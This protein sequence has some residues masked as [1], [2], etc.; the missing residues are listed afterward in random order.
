MRLFLRD[1]RHGVRWLAQSPGVAAAALAALALS[2]G[3]NT[4]IFSVV[5]TVL[6]KPLPVRDPA[7]L[8]QFRHYNEQRKMSS[9]GCNYADVADWRRELASFESIAALQQA[10][11]NLTGR[12]LSERVQVSKV[13]ANFLPLLGVRP[14]LGRDFLAGDD[15]PGAGRVAL[16]GHELWKRSFGANPDVAGATAILDGD[17]YTVIGV[18]PQGFRFVGPREEKSDLYVPLA[19]AEARG[20]K[21]VTVWAFGRLKPGVS[22]AQVR[23]ELDRAG[24]P[25]DR[26]SR[27]EAGPIGEWIVPDVRTG[28]YVLL[29]AVTLVLLIGC[30]NVASLLV[31][32]AAGRRR[33]MAIRAALGAG[34][35]RLVMQLLAESLPLGLAGGALGVLLAW[36]GIGLLPLVD[37]SRIPRLAD[38]RLDGAMLA[39]TAAVSI[40]TC[41][42]FSLA[43]ALDL[44]RTRLHETLKEGGRGGAASGRGGR[45]R[46]ALIVAEIAI[47]LVLAVGAVLMIRT[48]RNLTAVRPGFNPDHLLT[49]SVDLPRTRYKSVEQVQ[50]FHREA[51]ERIRAA[52][53]V[54]A[55]SVTNS[56]P[57]GGNYFRADFRV[58]GREYANPRE[59]P[60][61][62]L[63]SVDRDYL[64]TMQIRLV[65]GRFFDDRDRLGAPLAALIN[66]AAARRL[67][68]N[69]DPVGQRIGSPGQW[70]TVIGLVADIRH[71]DVSQESTSE[72]LIAFEQLPAMTLALT[73]R[74]DPAVYADP[75]RFAPQLRRAVES[76]DRIVALHRTLSMERIMANR[77]APR[78][79][80]MIV[81]ALFTVLALTL[82]AVGVY[83]VLAYSV[84]RR[85]QEIGI[86]MALGAGRSDVVGLVARESITLAAVGTAVGLAAA[87]GLTRLASGLL[88][89]VTPLD[90]IAYLGAAACLIAV[91][92]LASYIPARRA[93]RLDPIAAL[94]YE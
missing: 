2:I 27:I 83:G 86:R 13:N 43:P 66:Q 73:V 40:L 82:A 36:W 65:R 81:L 50:N 91:A 94:R 17:A 44:S 51:V 14:V 16:L 22:P 84:E 55:V 88:F 67:F 1:C 3:A 85:T 19:V 38:T 39:L 28:L 72:V 69:S 10:P 62:D 63:R 68:E 93:A 9:S 12:E 79:L 57:L 20:P 61:L 37:S 33:E 41:V 45:L 11:M 35:G 92:A 58:E 42:L 70:F 32:R 87:A 54:A 77:L 59:Y 31:A 48:F 7:G 25:P 76:V 90:P 15:R 71:T 30:A 75:L 5:Y 23:G 47:A 49:A 89:G 64:K 52:P 18:L 34:R 24:T 21:P 53:G 80:N 60:I 8:L 26:G 29:G 78:R 74:L 56:L 6:L 4:V 46:S